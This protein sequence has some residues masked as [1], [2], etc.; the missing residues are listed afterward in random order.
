MVANDDPHAAMSLLDAGEQLEPETSGPMYAGASARASMPA[1]AIPAMPYGLAAAPGY[2]PRRASKSMGVDSLTPILLLC[3]IV[4]LVAVTVVGIMNMPDPDPS[5]RETHPLV[6]EAARTIFIAGIASFAVSHFLVVA[7]LILLAVFIASKIMRFELPGAAYLRAAGVGALPLVALLG[8]KYL[9]PSD[10]TIRLVLIVAILPLAFYVLLYVFE[11][12]LTE[13]LV[14]YGFTLVFFVIGV[15]VSLVLSGVVATAGLAKSPAQ[16]DQAIREDMQKQWQEQMEQQRASRNPRGPQPFSPPGYPGGNNDSTPPTPVDPLQSRAESLQ[17]RLE[18]FNAR[19]FESASAEQIEREFA[20][21][22][23]DVTSA[24]ASM[25][26]RPE[27]Q[28]ITQSVKSIEQKITTLP[29]EKPDAAVFTALTPGA[30][31]DPPANGMAAL[32]QE[33]SFGKFDYRPPADA[34]LDLRASGATTHVWSKGLGSRSQLT[35]SLLPRKNDQQKRTWVLTRPFQKPV[36]EKMSLYFVEG[37]PGTKRVQVGAFGTLAAEKIEGQSAMGYRFFEYVAADGDQ[38]LVI[39]GQTRDDDSQSM[40]LFDMAARTLRLRPAGQ[41]VNDPFAP[42]RVVSRI[43]EDPES[44]SAILRKNPAAAEPL[45]IDLLSNPDAR[46]R[47]AAAEILPVVVSEKSLAKIEPLASHSD[48]TVANAV[49]GVLKRMKP[50]AFDA[51]AEVL[52]DLKSEDTFKRRNAMERLSKMQPDESRR[53]EVAAILEAI[54]LPERA[55]G[56]DVDT[57]AKALAVWPGDKTASR[58][59]PLL[60]DP[61]LWAPRRDA[62]LTAISGT[63]DRLT[64]NVVMKWLPQAPDKVAPILTRMGPL[65]EDETIRVLNIYFTNNTADGPK[66]RSACVQILSEV[67]SNKSLEVLGRASRDRRDVVTQEAAKQAIETIRARLAKPA[68]KPAS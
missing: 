49:R 48:E 6:L 59:A 13:A 4:G 54:V 18:A 67:G 34:K 27:W 26:D 62:L 23:V 58:I 20:P 32:G 66:V 30:P 41:P 61:K 19:N 25:K 5:R 55:F 10:M 31:F 17:R 39:R 29:S 42:E 53:N 37:Q 8:I 36:A 9:A 28:A 33:V 45:V 2:R 22:R 40:D 60:N 14:A 50:Q 46:T 15:F 52:L 12:L 51:L 43:A 35:V 44:V 64:V 21:I 47:R 16:I 11:L 57:A 56:F 24:T 65:A 63:R 68:T 7:P 3:F 38:W 1:P